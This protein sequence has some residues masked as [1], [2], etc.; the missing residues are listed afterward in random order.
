MKELEGSR[1]EKLNLGGK[2]V[3]PGFIDAHLHLLYGGLQVCL[4]TELLV[5]SYAISSFIFSWFW[6][7]LTERYHI[8]Y[9]PDASREAFT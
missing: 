2:I 5:M 3:V 9:Q 6:L 8:D 7:S 4:I 1:T